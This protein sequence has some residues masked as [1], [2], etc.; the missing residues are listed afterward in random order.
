MFRVDSANTGEG[1]ATNRP[2]VTASARTA[3]WPAREPVVAAEGKSE[4][5][6]EQQGVAGFRRMTC[7]QPGVELSITR[8][9]TS[10]C[11]FAS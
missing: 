3:A 5:R 4:R 11:A 10:R 6:R 1:L 8:R 9:A 7:S 2:C